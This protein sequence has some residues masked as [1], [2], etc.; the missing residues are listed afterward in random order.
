MPL[1]TRHLW[2]RRKSPHHSSAAIRLLLLLQQLQ[3]ARKLALLLLHM[4]HKTALLRH[5]RQAVHVMAP[6]SQ[7]PLQ[8]RRA[9]VHRPP[10]HKRKLGLL[11][12]NFQRT[13]PMFLL[14][15]HEPA[16]LQRWLTWHFQA[17]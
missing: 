10:M 9:S 12:H 15:T 4:R 1:S 8:P 17:I 5:Y 11:L 14:M 2:R 13:R 3:T 7:P 16:H 6:L